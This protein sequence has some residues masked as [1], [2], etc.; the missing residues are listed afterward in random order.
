MFMITLSEMEL[1]NINYL[2]KIVVF[3][4][5]AG[6]TET[7]NLLLIH[8]LSERHSIPKDTQENACLVKNNREDNIKNPNP[9]PNQNT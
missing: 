6:G 1:S 8:P 3:L 5:E 4:T 9:K 7:L 2:F